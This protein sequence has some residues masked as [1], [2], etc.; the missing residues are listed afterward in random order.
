MLSAAIGALHN[1]VV[2]SITWRRIIEDV[3]ARSADITAEK[4]AALFLRGV[5]VDIKNDLG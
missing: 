2:H 1:H 5:V 3:I 4:E